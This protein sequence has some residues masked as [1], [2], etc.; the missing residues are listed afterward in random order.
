MSTPSY[1]NAEM[2]DNIL[3]QA[4]PTQMEEAPPT[5]EASSSSQMAYQMT[6]PTHLAPPTQMA[7]PTFYSNDPNYP[8]IPIMPISDSYDERIDEPTIYVY[9]ENGAEFQEEQNYSNPSETYYD[10]HTGNSQILPVDHKNYST[11]TVVSMGGPINGGGGV[12][13]RQAYDDDD[14]GDM[15]HN[16]NFDQIE[17][18]DHTPRPLEASEPRNWQPNCEF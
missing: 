13:W 2:P 16:L 6:P 4:P 11:P 10:L 5:S 9:P 14:I 17:M 18:V 12:Y 8:N 15:G 1:F 7:T 3:E